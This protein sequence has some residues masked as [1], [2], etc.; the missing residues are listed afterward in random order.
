MQL[1]EDK[2]NNNKQTQITP[3][4]AE[5]KEGCEANVTHYYSA[6]KHGKSTRTE[7]SK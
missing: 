5:D 1:P 7:H 4:A 3:S 6:G 2:P